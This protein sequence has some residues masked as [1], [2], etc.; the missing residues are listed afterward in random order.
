MQASFFKT[1]LIFLILVA[2]ASSAARVAVAN[3]PA[4]VEIE[5]GD[6]RRF[7]HA[8]RL[9][10]NAANPGQVYRTQYLDK[11]SIGLKDMFTLRIKTVDALVRAVEQFPQHYDVLPEFENMI[12]EIE[13]GIRGSFRNF[14]QI[15]PEVRLP[16]V[17]FV[18]GAMK[19]GGTVSDNGLLIGT[20]VLKPA[21]GSTDAAVPVV[22][23]EVVHF[24]QPNS[25]TKAGLQSVGGDVDTL[26]GQAINEGAADF[27]GH[28]ISGKRLNKAAYEYGVAHEAQLWQEFK[29]VMHGTELMP[30]MGGRPAGGVWNRRPRD[31]GYFIGHQIVATYYAKSG[32]KRQAIAEILK[33]TDFAAFLTKSG[34]DEE[35]SD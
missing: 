35:L 1:L 13:S 5:F 17:Y 14:K 31:L 34:Y 28:T 29:A 22:A 33:I 9:A 6:I 3:D 7:I 8:R 32:D 24:Q 11:G 15:Y 21:F 4:A 25:Q 18:V 2:P 12:A 10:E 16:S 26:L 30:W 20:E 19:T 27:I 23:H